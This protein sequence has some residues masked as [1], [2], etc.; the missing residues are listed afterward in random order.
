MN[1]EN[2]TQHRFEEIQSFN[3]KD[4]KLSTKIHLLC[5][6][7]YVHHPDSIAF[8]EIEYEE[9]D[10]YEIKS[11]DVVVLNH[12]DTV[13][14]YFRQGETSK[15]KVSENNN[16]LPFVLEDEEQLLDWLLSEE[17]SHV[18]LA[19]KRN[20]EETIKRIFPD[21][22]ESDGDTHEDFPIEILV[23][24]LVLLYFINKYPDRREE[25]LSLLK[26][27]IRTKKAIQPYVN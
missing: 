20:K 11:A 27:S 24:R 1:K 5:I 26:E 7:K 6:D 13:E 18:L 12:P 22:I 10:E 3:I 4:P 16:S 14:E 2:L 21:Y 8:V 23:S 25:V 9:D 17:I 19:S 15:Q